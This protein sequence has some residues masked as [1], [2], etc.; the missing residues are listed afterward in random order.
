MKGGWPPPYARVARLTPAE[1]KTLTT[2]DHPREAG[3]VGR[4]RVVMFVRL[5]AVL[6]VLSLSGCGVARRAVDPLTPWPCVLDP[7]LSREPCRGYFKNIGGIAP[8]P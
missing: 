3:R 5:C 6:A 7:D 4:Q 2:G 8:F 1:G